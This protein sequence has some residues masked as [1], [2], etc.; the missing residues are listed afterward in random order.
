MPARLSLIPQA[1]RDGD[2][3]QVHVAARRVPPH[4]G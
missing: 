4:G 1:P 3:T 2:G